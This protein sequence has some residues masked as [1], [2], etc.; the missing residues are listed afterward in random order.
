MDI[1]MKKKYEID[2]K[3]EEEYVCNKLQMNA[4]KLE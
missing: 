4:D 1:K 3:Q 2:F